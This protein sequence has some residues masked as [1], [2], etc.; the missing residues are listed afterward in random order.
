MATVI[1]GSDNFDS[2]PPSFGR[3]VRSAGA[4]TTTSTSLVDVTG[5]T[6]TIATGANP[7]AYGCIQTVKN[8][9]LGQAHY[10]NINIDGALELGNN[11]MVI[12][13]E[14]AAYEQNGSFSGQSAALSAGVHTIKEQF[15]VGGGTA[16]IEAS[17]NVKHQF[18]V[19]E[20]K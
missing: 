12:S 5:A 2:K 16:I 6:V 7:V 4:I 10:Y 13:Q 3:V 8:S 11:G 1:R 20:I 15:R 9:T 14:V 19:R 17:A 18:Y